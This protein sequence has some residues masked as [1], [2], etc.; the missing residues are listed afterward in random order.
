MPQ[1]EVNSQTAIFR[2]IYVNVGDLIEPGTEL[3]ELETLKT[4]TTFESEVRG[5]LREILVEEGDE[6][7]VHDELFVLTETEDEKYLY[8]KKISLNESDYQGSSEGK[9]L[10]Q[11]L[12]EKESER[13]QGTE[14]KKFDGPEGVEYKARGLSR[15]EQGVNQTLEYSRHQTISTY[16]ELLCDTTDLRKY[17]EELKKGES[18]LSDPF[19]GII[20]WNF[21]Q[22][23][24]K[25]PELNSFYLNDQICQYNECNLGFTIDMNNELMISNIC[26]ADNLTIEEFLNAFFDVQ[27]RGVQRKLTT[28]ELTGS[29]IGITSLATIGIT[30]HVPILPPYTI[31]IL[32]HSAP[33]IKNTECEKTILGVTYDHRVHSGLK[34]G[35]LLR[36][37]DKSIQKKTKD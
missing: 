10:K 1:I 29:T 35:R 6:V 5:Y 26:H 2:S 19:F 8:E 9:S 13:S 24:K 25:V 34:I 3:C 36:F 23:I 7:P 37:L 27:K 18:F 16:M 17:A 12:L 11:I 4:T 15:F 31:I 30:K 22:T 21:I 28:K 33:L 32:A 14:I 20:A